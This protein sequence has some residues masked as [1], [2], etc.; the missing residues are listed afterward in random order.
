MKIR[1]CYLLLLLLVIF[2]FSAQHSLAQDGDLSFLLDDVDNIIIK[3]YYKYLVGLK[4]VK[5]YISPIPKGLS[6]NGVKVD[7]LQTEAE[8]RLRRAGLYDKTA[9]ST[10]TIDLI[11][12]ENTNSFITYKLQFSLLQPAHLERNNATI[13]SKTWERRN[14]GGEENNR[15]QTDARERV[16]KYID[17]FIEDLRTANSQTVKKNSPTSTNSQAI[18]QN[19]QV[20]TTQKD[21]SPFTATYVG[22]NSPP[23]IEV[24]NDSNRTMYFDFGQGKMTAYTIPSGSSQKINLTEGNYNY[25]ASA[26]RV[27]P[28]EGQELFKK[29]Y[30]YNWRYTIVTVTR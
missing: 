30:F 14:I 12:T 3:D 5:L 8:I 13:D 7:Q 15:L 11:E 21:D 19:P 17:K 18:Q 26:L 6:K 24:F 10:L 29:G 27:R 2:N 4:K 9:A 25:K 16:G 22:G 1:N 28:L 23:T 20:K